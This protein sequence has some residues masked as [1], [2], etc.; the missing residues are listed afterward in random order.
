VGERTSYAPGAFSWVD[1]GTTDAEGAKAFYR[2]LFGWEAEDVPA[3]EGGTYTML[4][5]RGREVAGLY[6]MGDEQRDGGVGANWLS[7]V[8]V[9]DVAAATDLAR[10]LGA[11]VIAPPFDVMSAG[12]MSILQDPQG[13]G[14]ALWEARDHP[15]A[16]LVNEPGALVLNQLNTSDPEEAARFYSGLFGW[17]LLP[18]ASDPQPYWGIQNRGALNGGMMALPP[19]DPSPP[20]WL[21]YFATGDLDAT[22]ARIGELGGAVLVPPMPIPSGR[23]A[24]ARDPQGAVFALFEGPV[25]P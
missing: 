1:L 13:A 23:I 5:L 25:D 21:V 4:R 19:G 6:A 10:D 24:V 8:T 11:E 2:A 3:G 22:V 17:A 9:E 20:H 18:V 7:Y 15:G 14:I 12:R 16:R